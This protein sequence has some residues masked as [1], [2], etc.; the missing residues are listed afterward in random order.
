LKDGR[1]REDHE[2]PFDRPD[3]SVSRSDGRVDHAVRVAVP[4]MFVPV[5]V[6]RMSAMRMPVVVLAEA[7]PIP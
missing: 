4:A 2:R 1:H 3:A 7:E 6:M 5:M